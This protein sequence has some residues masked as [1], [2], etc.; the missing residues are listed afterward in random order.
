MLILGIPTEWGG[1]NGLIGLS[2]L[3]GFGFFSRICWSWRFVVK[4]RL[5]RMIV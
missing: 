2:C 5:R 4:A 3:L 1:C